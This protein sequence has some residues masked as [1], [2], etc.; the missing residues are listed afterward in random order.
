MMAGVY[1]GFQVALELSLLLE[2]LHHETLCSYSE[3]T[4]T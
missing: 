4:H 1:L 2:R 3:G